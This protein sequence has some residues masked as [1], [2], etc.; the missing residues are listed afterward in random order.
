MPKKKALSKQDRA[1]RKYIRDTFEYWLETLHIL[2]FTVSYFFENNDFDGEEAEGNGTQVFNICTN[3]PYRSAEV[4]IYPEAF[5]MPRER[6]SLLLCHEAMHIILYPLESARLLSEDIY[7]RELEAVVDLL[8][9][10][11]FLAKQ[12]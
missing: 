7:V 5:K 9:H 3:F 2:P 10:N 4:R 1:N 12:A 11:F 6:Q 8:A